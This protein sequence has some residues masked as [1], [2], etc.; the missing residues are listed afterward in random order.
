MVFCVTNDPGLMQDMFFEPLSLLLLSRM[1]ITKG[2]NIGTKAA[3]P[4]T[5]VHMLM[6]R[7]EAK[8]K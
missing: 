7:K 8:F 1:S 2:K 4:I 3:K 6:V 5:K